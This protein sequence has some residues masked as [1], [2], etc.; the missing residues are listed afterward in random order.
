MHVGFLGGDP[1]EVLEPGQAAVLDNEV[2]VGEVGGGVV[3][4]GDVERVTVERTNGRALVDVDV[5]DAQ[6]PAQL[7]VA[8]GPRV[9]ELGFRAG[10]VWSGWQR[11]AAISRRDAGDADLG[12]G[13][14][15][16]G[17]AGREGAGGRRGVL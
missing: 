14:N 2:Q 12:R 5:A 8:V 17:G 6:F 4:V 7:E 16:L 10:P 1:A 15:R 9:V 13:Q 11:A 3:D